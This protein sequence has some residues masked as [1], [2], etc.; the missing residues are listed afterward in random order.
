MAGRGC[1]VNVAELEQIGFVKAG[2]CSLEPSLKS[3][4]RFT[5]SSHRKDRVLY[6]FAV[7][8]QVKYIG[9]CDNAGTCFGSR[10]S[11]YQGIMGAGT[12]KRVVELVSSALAKGACVDLLVWKPVDEFSVHGL[13]VDLIKG[14]ENPLI[15]RAKPEWNIQSK[16][17]EASTILAG[18]VE[19]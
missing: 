14:L 12:N 2:S 17:A 10:M 1:D 15:Q 3:G 16:P 9:S 19:Q 18:A 5:V 4:V 8:G 6:A 11:R 7:D 13:K